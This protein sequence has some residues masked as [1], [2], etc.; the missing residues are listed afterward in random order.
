MDA[1]RWR[2]IKSLFEAAQEFDAA[3]REKF[4]AEACAGGSDLRRED[5]KLTHRI[6]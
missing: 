2:K 5:E 6:R 3:K 4:L 1:Q